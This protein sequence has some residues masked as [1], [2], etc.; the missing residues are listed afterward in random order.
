M[1]KVK[2]FLINHPVVTYYFTAFLISWGGL[3][4]AIG[5][6]DKISPKP[7]NAPFLLMY[8]I[9][10]AGPFLA[11]ILLTG[12]YQGM[13]GYR[14]LI[15]RLRIWNVS[16]KWYLASFFIAPVTVFAALFAL[17]LISPA[18][19]PAIFDS[20]INPVALKFGLPG[21]EP[22]TL[23]L[24]VFML[25]IFNG[26][27]EEVGWTGFATPQLKASR[28]LFSRG[29]NLGFIWG[30]WHLLSNYVGSE[31]SAG[32]M[33]LSLYL[34][35]VLFSFLPPFRIL[36]MWVY[37]RTGSLL[38]AI[39]MHAS[40]DVFWILSMPKDITGQ[41]RLIWYLV[42]AIVLWGIV[43]LIETESTGISRYRVVEWTNCVGFASKQGRHV[44]N[45][46]S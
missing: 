18:F 8:L 19:L 17:T 34:F 46:K 12:F 3:V 38:I 23:F 5:G 43:A 4:L 22:M 6:P 2:D 44:E 28:S 7:A 45:S 20:G 24:F 26:F 13:K 9:T 36:M 1:G 35:V 33:P 30:L 27:V 15:Y 11:G 16:Y 37:D 31:D 10:V 41:E 14:D 32:T 39:L 42:W 25:G 40:L 29:F 21:N